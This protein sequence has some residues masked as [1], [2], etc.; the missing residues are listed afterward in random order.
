VIAKRSILERWALRVLL[1]CWILMSC[2]LSC[3]I[4]TPRQKQKIL[5]TNFKV[6]VQCTTLFSNLE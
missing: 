5:Q 6:K 2:H 3:Y 1:L 4:P